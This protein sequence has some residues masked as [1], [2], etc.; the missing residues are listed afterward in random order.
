MNRIIKWGWLALG[1]FQVVHLWSVEEVTLLDVYRMAGA[2]VALL[3]IQR[4]EV[5]IFDPAEKSAE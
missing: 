2:A 3:V 1:V 5:A 4:A